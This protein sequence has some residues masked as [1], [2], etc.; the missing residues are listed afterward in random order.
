MKTI[1]DKSKAICILG[2]HRS[3]TSSVAGAFNLLGAYL[4]EKEKLGTVGSDN[5]KGFWEHTEIRAIQL[6]LLQQLDRKWNCVLPLPANWHKTA[7]VQP[8]R[9]EIAKV[10]A[11]QFAGQSVWAWKDPQTCLLLPLWRDILDASKTELVCV[12]VVRN[13]L[14]VAQSL[15]KR[16]SLLFNNALGIW[17][18]YNLAA[19]DGSAGLP[20]VFLSYERF[21]ADWESELRRCWTELRLHWPKDE[22]MLRARLNSFVDPALRH[23]NSSTDQLQ[24]LPR[25]VLDLYQLLSN[26]CDGSAP[27]NG[28]FDAA[29]QRLKVEFHTYASFFEVGPPPPPTGWTTRTLR[30][31]KRSIR[32]RMPGYQA[33]TTSS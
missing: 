1:K 32:K 21:L 13:P 23:N 2:M 9:H 14:D 7:A 18:H 4:G 31:W 33:R 15:V 8:F 3:G 20:T 5:L 28:D 26:A 17:L 22:T 25:P 10:V 24:N 6:R 29:V 19:L 16:N 27:R 30:R 11:D 12:F